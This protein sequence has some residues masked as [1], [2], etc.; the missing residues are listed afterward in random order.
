[1]FR[2]ILVAALIVSALALAKQNHWF[3]KAGIVGTCVE[4][5]APYGD[6]AQYWSCEQGVLTGF[7][8]LRHNACDPHG[9][10]A[11]RQLWRCPTPLVSAPGGIF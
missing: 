5:A 2:I 10:S 8:S 11:G 9:V 1:M 4:V 3:E 6:E 7:P